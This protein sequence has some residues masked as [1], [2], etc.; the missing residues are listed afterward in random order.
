MELLAPAGNWESFLAAV[1][2]G[3]DAVYLGGQ[4]YSAR[5]SA[6]NFNLPELERALDYAHKYRK[7]V[8]VTVNTLISTDE[9]SAVLDYLYQLYVRGVDAVIVQD[10]GMVDLAGQILPD[11]RLHAS[12][13]MTIHNE[14][15]VRFLHEKG[16]KRTVLARECSYDDI[17]IIRQELPQVEL[18]VFVHG[19]LCYSYSGQCLFSSWLGKDGNRGQ[20]SHVV[21]LYLYQDGEPLAIAERG[22]CT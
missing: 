2:N 20:R 10:A 4:H 15:G 3:A 7:K 21:C 11:L 16:I 8:Y 14:Q 9:M 22:R 18:E 17:R 5:Q 13:Q 6:D 1:H 19:A 12:T